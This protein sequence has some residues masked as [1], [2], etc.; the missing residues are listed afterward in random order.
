MSEP[1]MTPKVDNITGAALILDHAEHDVHD[2][3][4]FTVSWSTTTAAT[5]DHRTAISFTTPAASAGL[6]HM[7][8]TFSATD[9]AEVFILE[10]PAIADGTQGFSRTIRNRN[11]TSSNLSAIVDM[12]AAPFPNAVEVWTEA[13]LAAGTFLGVGTELFHQL[14]GGGSGPFS[15][16]GDT[17]ADQEFI[18]APGTDYIV[19]IQNVGATANSH[20]IT[21]NWSE[22]VNG[23]FAN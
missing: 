11:R 12:E 19:Y 22:D 7:T 6:A 16:G 1:V 9:P 17:R 5:D 14:L 18:L 10:S 21:L 3:K 4:A 15:A 13:Q 2:G 8:M 23:D 20:V